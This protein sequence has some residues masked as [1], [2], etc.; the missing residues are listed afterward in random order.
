M[1]GHNCPLIYPW[2]PQAS[3][4][5]TTIKTKTDNWKSAIFVSPPYSYQGEA[6][7]PEAWLRLV[8][9]EPHLVAA[10]VG[11]ER[12]VVA[13]AEVLFALE[14]RRLAQGTCQTQ[15]LWAVFTLPCEAPELSANERC[16]GLTWTRTGRRTFIPVPPE[17][18]ETPTARRRSCQAGP[19]SWWP[20]RWGSGGFAGRWWECGWR[21][22]DAE[23]EHRRSEGT[24][25][26][27]W[28]LPCPWP[29]LKETLSSTFQRLLHGAGFK[30]Y[31]D[32]RW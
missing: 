25:W 31:I 19:R 18:L 21:P 15:G 28:A 10:S 14:G 7:G 23:T 12:R 32:R 20:C 2:F 3:I 1:Q 8:L 27:W 17:R 29:R 24:R 5:L 6:A 4:Q 16:Y 22:S 30:F 13:A 9:Q 26:W 11:L